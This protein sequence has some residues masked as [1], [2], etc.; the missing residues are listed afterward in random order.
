MMDLVRLRDDIENLPKVQHKEIA[1]ILAT[2]H[3]PMDENKNGMFVNLSKVSGE[4]LSK[5]AEY[6]SYLNLQQ[7]NLNSGETEREGLKMQFFAN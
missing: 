6:V 7:T 2:Y 1:R 4:A 5:L 3:V